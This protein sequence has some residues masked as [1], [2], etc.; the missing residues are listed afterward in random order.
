MS[1][2]SMLNNESQ[3][4]DIGRTSHLTPGSVEKQNSATVSLSGA[5]G[6]G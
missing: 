6:W 5:C 2:N 4:A 1:N 3:G